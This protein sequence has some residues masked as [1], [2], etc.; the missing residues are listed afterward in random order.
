MPLNL[1]PFRTVF[2]LCQQ[3][4]SPVLSIVLTVLLSSI[5]QFGNAASSAPVKDDIKVLDYNGLEAYL[6]KLEGR[7]VVINFWA[8]WCVPCVKELPYLEQV[9]KQYPEEQ[10]TVVLVSLDFSNQI[11]S[12]LKPF[13][14]EHN[15]Q[16][17]VVVLDDPDQTIWIDKVDPEWGGAIP[18]TVIRKGDKKKFY[19][20]GFR[21][22]DDLN[23][24]IR[25][26]INS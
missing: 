1:V 15:I 24:Q 3:I 25:S 10:V 21:S 22:F 6:A 19:Q 13:L 18:V 8:S 9:T 7:T 4:V 17:R 2:L 11:N 14:K 5:F 26:F 20:R 12:K 23:T 16:S